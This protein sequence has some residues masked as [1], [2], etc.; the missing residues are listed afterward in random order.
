[1]TDHNDHSPMI[2]APPDSGVKIRMYNPGFGDCFLLAFRTNS[3]NAYYMLIDC[4][5]HHNYS[6]GSDRIK[7][8]VSDIAA[9]TNNHIDTVVITHEHTDHVYGFKYAR[10]IFDDIKIDNLW[11]SWAENPDDLEANKL[12]EKLGMKIQAIQSTIKLLRQPDKEFSNLLKGILDF[13]LAEELAAAGGKA[14]QL[15][16]LKQKIINKLLGPKDYLNPG[17]IKTLP[18]LSEYKFY[19]LGPPR[20]IE[21]IKQLEIESELYLKMPGLNEHTA[22][23]TAAIAF[24]ANGG[25]KKENEDFFELSN[26]FDTSHRIPIDKADNIDFFKEH[27]GFSRRSRKAPPWR[28]IDNDWLYSA[29]ELALDINNKTNN[30]SLAFA[31]ELTTTEPSKILLFPGDAQVGN[32]LS[33]HELSWP[34]SE[35]ESEPTVIKD[36]LEKCVFYKV[37]HHGSHN[38]TLKEKG[39]EMMTNPDLLAMI[40]VDEHWANDRDWEHPDQ[41]LLKRLEE[42]TRGRILRSDKIPKFSQKPPKPEMATVEEWEETLSHISWDHSSDRLWIEYS[43]A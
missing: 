1:M 14:E 3:N 23:A 28:R 43:V 11:I 10:E 20:D 25:P 7:K 38:A 37:G 33:W 26:P 29:E 6:G 24:G 31:I 13:E 16:Y 19:V 34:N 27:Y 42:K 39:L 5:V 41:K 22:F 30:T 4:G 12:K 40:P 8:V 9:A 36:L 18:E 17:D 21:L 35:C 15:E 2:M 32:W